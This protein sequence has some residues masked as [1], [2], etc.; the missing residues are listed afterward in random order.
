LW[1]V[2]DW[3][4]KNILQI[5][6]DTVGDKYLFPKMCVASTV[7][8][9]R[10]LHTSTMSDRQAGSVLSEEQ[11]REIYKYKLSVI[12]PKNHQFW[13]QG[14]DT[15]LRGHS[16]PLAWKFGVSPK[17]IRDI[18][19]RR[20][21]AFATF[22]WWSLEEPELGNIEASGSASIKVQTSKLIFSKKI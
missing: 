21:W 22:Q 2:S 9:S 19:N 6:T 13:N 11:A 3:N 18:W 16:V 20:T 4:F 8:D 7:D 14:A 1:E 5:Q 10:F 17:T 15:R 12:C